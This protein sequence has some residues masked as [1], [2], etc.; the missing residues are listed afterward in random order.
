MIFW[1][2]HKVI[3]KAIACKCPVRFDND[4]VIKSK[5]YQNILCLVY[6]NNWNLELNNKNNKMIFR[7]CFVLH[8]HNK[9]YIIAGLST[10]KNG[11]FRTRIHQLICIEFIFVFGFIYFWKL[12]IRVALPNCVPSLCAWTLTRPLD[13]AWIYDFAVSCPTSYS[14]AFLAM[15]KF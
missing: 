10:S 7:V 4:F 8:V 5:Y 6:L 9:A 1:L 2:Y 14:R 11:L 3:V 13:I 12:K 15:V